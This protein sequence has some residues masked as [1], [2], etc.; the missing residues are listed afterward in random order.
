MPYPVIDVDGAEADDVIGTL[1]E[2]SQENDLTEHPLFQEPKPFLIVSAD[3]DFQ[4][5]QKW[6]NVKQWSPMRKKFVEIKDNPSQVLMEHIISG[7]K[8][9]GVPNILSD[10]DVFT[11]GKRQRPIRKTLVAEWKTKPPEE[12]VTGD[13]ACWI[14][15]QQ[16]KW[17]TYHRRP[18]SSKMKSFYNTNYSA[19]R[20]AV[21]FVDILNATT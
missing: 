2:Y 20:T 6:Q 13:M 9:D 14:H 1:A 5:L 17:L 21:K 4:Q 7:D 8:G 12:W 18:P 19:V 11:E 16:K 15:P 10:D 3:H